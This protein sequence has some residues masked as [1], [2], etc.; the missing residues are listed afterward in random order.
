MPSRSVLRAISAVTI[1]GAVCLLS[2]GCGDNAPAA[3]DWSAA[4]VSLRYADG[5]SPGQV[6]FAEAPASSGCICGA[7]LSAAAGLRLVEQGSFQYRGKTGTGLTVF[8]VDSTADAAL[9]GLAADDLPDSELS[10]TAT[11]L[12]I[13]SA[14]PVGGAYTFTRLVLA[15]FPAARID[16]KHVVDSNGE[17]V[18]QIHW[19]VFNLESARIYAFNCQF[20]P[21]AEAQAAR[22]CEAA[23]ATF[24][25]A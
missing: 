4:G 11:Q 17:F 13:P 2:V 16:V 14:A 20:V 12:G 21:G 9:A 25:A 23:V 6:D 18:D 19:V 1:I 22:A 24:A 7:A 8:V 10:A 5:L 3:G 15:D